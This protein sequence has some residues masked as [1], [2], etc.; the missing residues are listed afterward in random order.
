MKIRAIRVQE[1]KEAEYEGG[2]TLVEL[3]VAL[4]VAS[5]L[6]LGVIAAFQTTQR[7]AAVGEAREHIYQNARAAMDLLAREIKNAYIDNRNPDLVF[8]SADGL[9]GRGN[10]ILEYD[11]ANPTTSSS[12]ALGLGNAQTPHGIDPRGR[13][14]FELYADETFGSVYT[15]VSMK[16]QDEDFYPAP[17][18]R[19]GPP[20]R[21]DFTCMT[22]NFPGNTYNESK[23]AEVRYLITTETFLDDI[24]NDYDGNVDENDNLGA[25][26]GV[27]D[28]I[29][30]DRL[31]DFH[32][33]T[34]KIKALKM[35]H[36]RRALG[37]DTTDANMPLVVDNNSFSS[38]SIPL[39][40]GAAFSP[41][42]PL[43]RYPDRAFG[44]NATGDGDFLT[45]NGA[46]N[47]GSY[48]YDLQFEF[49]GKIAIALKDDG[50]PEV[51][52]VGWGYQDVRGE[53]VGTDCNGEL[54]NAN[55]QGAFAIRTGTVSVTRGSTTVDGSAGGVSWSSTNDLLKDGLFFVWPSGATEFDAGDP[56]SHVYRI[57][58]NTSNTLTLERRY[59][60]VTNA[61]ANYRIIEPT[62]AN[63]ILDNTGTL[64]NPIYPEDLGSDGIVDDPLDD[65][66][67]IPNNV[68]NNNGV[69]TERSIG[70]G[71]ER[72][73]SRVMGIWDSRSPDP[74]NPRRASEL[75]NWD[76]DGDFLTVSDNGIDDDRD[77]Q[78]DDRLATYFDSDGNSQTNPNSAQFIDYATPESD[79]TGTTTIDETN[80]FLDDDSDGL[81]DDRFY[82]PSGKPEG[83]DEPDEANPHDDTLPKAVRI[84]I[85]VR[86][87]QQT[88]EPVVLSTTVW[89]ST[90]R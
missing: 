84:T 60:G 33:D 67:G 66:S 28:L 9:A 46:E 44:N 29:A 5:V 70:E 62:Q 36:L 7:T 30:M 6:M 22:S 16:A 23:L 56:G 8:V 2:V 50:S 65:G 42:D 19:P 31:E 41:A 21:L 3:L 59:T 18:L 27:G 51:W 71:N 85:A 77:G 24:D 76:D 48:I 37:V 61:T 54:T 52:G 72:L 73:D 17:A 25:L 63:G 39:W 78:A 83:I 74:R 15:V 55:D 49:Y 68:S 86:D 45:S 90:A 11:P 64:I 38:Y 10:A 47:V 12:W 1:R 80:D 79:D 89:L 58:S 13:R 82:E 43:G 87:P 32:P 35:F 53:D 81:V 75:N 20:D 57:V 26:T 4:A 69:L 88:L 34:K 40:T 14:V